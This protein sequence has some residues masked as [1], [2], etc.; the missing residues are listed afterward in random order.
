VFKLVSLYTW[1]DEVAEFD[2][3]FRSQHLPALQALP[4]I[5]RLTT[6]YFAETPLGEPPYYA[7]TE[8]WFA[9]REHLEQALVTRQAK[10]AEAVLSFAHGIATTLYATEEVLDV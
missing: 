3:R 6:S 4:G 9:T 2:R 7:M 10:E 1:P 5:Q 8:A